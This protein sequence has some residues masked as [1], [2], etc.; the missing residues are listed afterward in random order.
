[1]RAV[2]VSWLD[3]IVGR[4]DGARPLAVVELG[5]GTRPLLSELAG[6][7]P[8]GSSLLAVDMDED[9]IREAS[10]LIPG[11]TYICA[12]AAR[13][14]AEL[15]R[16]FHLALVGRPDLLARPQGWQSA[17]ARIARL[18]VPGGFVALTA[19]A[20]E[21]AAL[22]ARWLDGAGFAAVERRAIAS[23]GASWL[24]LAGRP[25][26]GAG[27]EATGAGPGP[28][29][30]VWEEGEGAMCD[31]ATGLCTGPQEGT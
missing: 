19:I 4:L 23:P 26:A 16:R 13:L 30:V 2:T 31:L 8:E 29:V 20:S 27:A 10:G 24:V 5:C 15:D 9:A 7:L 21:E 11:A 18:L 22:A 12:D 28:E 14:P 6:R 17:L 3:A 1:M 25:E